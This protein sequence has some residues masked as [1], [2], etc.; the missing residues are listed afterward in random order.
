MAEQDH[1]C[2]SNE[3]CSW[4][5]YQK[6][7]AHLWPLPFF[8]S[9]FLRGRSFTASVKSSF[10]YILHSIFDLTERWKVWFCMPSPQG[11][12]FILDLTILSN[13]MIKFFYFSFSTFVCK[14]LYL[15]GLILFVWLQLINQSDNTKNITIKLYYIWAFT[16]TVVLLLK[17]GLTFIRVL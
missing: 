1:N 15:L 6:D 11:L 10:L 4:L 9:E 13:M 7:K 12:S 5:P 2:I 16:S 14:V 17:L 8:Q 3:L